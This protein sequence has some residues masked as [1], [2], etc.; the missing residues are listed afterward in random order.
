MLS[1][2]LKYDTAEG[3]FSQNIKYDENSIVVD[4]KVVKVFK[5]SD[6]INL[7]WKDLI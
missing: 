1:Y 7:P 5:E 4:N 2:L 3:I 6:P